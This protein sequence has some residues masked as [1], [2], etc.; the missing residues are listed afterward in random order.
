[1]LDMSSREPLD[2]L[3]QTD[4]LTEEF[5]FFKLE[6]RVINGFEQTPASSLGSPFS[7][8]KMMA[9]CRGVSTA[10]FV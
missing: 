8:K 9:F 2:K 1:M 4:R 7:E 6:M 5:F 10:S 3:G